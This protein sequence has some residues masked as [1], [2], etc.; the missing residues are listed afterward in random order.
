MCLQYHF[1]QNIV[2]LAFTYYFNYSSILTFAHTTYH[3]LPTVCPHFHKF[4]I[5][6]GKTV[7]KMEFYASIIRILNP[8]YKYCIMCAHIYCNAE[9]F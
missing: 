9:V 4:L 7:L 5:N 1:I 6:D 8:L 2:V 3:K